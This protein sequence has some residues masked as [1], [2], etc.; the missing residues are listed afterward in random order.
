MTCQSPVAR[1][2]GI[3]I[4]AFV[5]MGVGTN[6][7]TSTHYGT[8]DKRWLNEALSY[9]EY[10]MFLGLSATYWWH[11][12]VVLHRPAPNVIGV[13]SGADSC[14]GSRSRRTKF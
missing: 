3:L 1:G 7:L 4:S 5:C 2:V 14:R 9:F 6:T 13:D 12:H 11:K 8:S 10:P